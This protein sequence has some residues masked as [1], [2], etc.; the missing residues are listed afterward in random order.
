MAYSEA[1]KKYAQKLF[2]TLA[3]TGERKYTYNEIA[4]L[5]K[6]HFKD[7][8]VDVTGQAV[9]GL[10]EITVMNWATIQHD[11]TGHSWNDIYEKTIGM[12][13][14]KAVEEIGLVLEN[15]ELAEQ[16]EDVPQF[17]YGMAVT[18]YIKG[19]AYIL[20]NP[21]GG[22]KEAQW[23]VEFGAREMDRLKKLSKGGQDDVQKQILE[24]LQ[25]RN[26]RLQEIAKDG[27]NG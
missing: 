27:H 6:E 20:S 18:A 12:K 5:T 22:I 4:Q 24:M 14:K 16:I 8:P 26:Q 23:M 1:V 21:I 11:I 3:D 7:A 15:Q 25:K 9:S 10:S 13:R 17:R 2:F 19:F